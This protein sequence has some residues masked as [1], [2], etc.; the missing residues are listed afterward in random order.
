MAGF[1]TLHGR[2]TIQTNYRGIPEY[3]IPGL[4]PRLFELF[5]KEVPPGSRVLDLACGA[6]A[7]YQ[8]LADH[9]YEVIGCD[10]SPDLCPVPCLK[11]DLNKD[12]AHIIGAD[13]FDAVTA[14]EL[15]EHLE[16]PRHTFRETNRLL[17]DGGKL[18]ITTPNASGLHSR[19]KFLFTGRFAMFDDEQ[20]NG[21]GHMRPVT[22]WE[23]DKMLSET[24]FAIRSLL[25]HSHQDNIPHTM[26]EVVKL[27]SSIMVRP[28]VRGTAGGQ[29]MM[30]I[31]EKVRPIGES[32]A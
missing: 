4:H 16:N 20:Y 9:G 3:A 2:P 30:V 8:R 29:V 18:F 19:V 23:L 31:A 14:I 21:I 10:L 6:G 7:W 32:P 11:V 27:A 17:K 24:G 25:F 13:R 28:F 15:I 12:F 22:F 5:S 1:F 26:G